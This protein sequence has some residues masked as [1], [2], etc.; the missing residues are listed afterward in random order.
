MVAGRNGNEPGPRA[1]PRFLIVAALALLLAGCGRASA[2][3]SLPAVTGLAATIE[4][5]IRDLPNGRIVWESTWRLCWD[6]YPGAAAYELQALTGEGASPRLRR[7]SGRCFALQA[8]A[9][10]NRASQG[11]FN[12]DLQLAL[13]QGQLAYRVRAI[14]SDGRTSEWS[15]AWAVGRA[16]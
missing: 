2:N 12:R 16:P 11:L 4:D 5:S 9:G 8:A 1:R 3:R 14:L 7:L 10:E 15:A 13:Q 6:E